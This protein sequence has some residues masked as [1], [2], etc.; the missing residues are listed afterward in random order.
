M[1]LPGLRRTFAASIAMRGID[2]VQLPTS[3]LAQVDSSVG[4]KT[5]INT[6]AGKNLVGA[7]YQPRMVLADV[8]CLDSL[9]PREL[10]AGYAEMVKHAAIGDVPMIDW[11]ERNGA[12]LLAGDAEARA[13]AV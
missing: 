13:H 4:G 10:R 2:F 6:R 1:P 8:A 11:F 3:L 12:A 7:F 5:A 9:P